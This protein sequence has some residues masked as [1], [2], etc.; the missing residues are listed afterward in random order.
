MKFERFEKTVDMED[1]DELVSFLKSHFRYYTANSWNRATSY[2]NN[3]KL[4][5]LN[6]PEKIRDKAYSLV[7]G[8]VECPDWNFAVE[9]AF[10]SFLKE[11]G[12]NAGF[13]GR[14]GGYIVMYETAV[15][16]SGKTV[17]YPGRGIDQYE[18]FDDEDEWDFHRLQERVK[19]VQRFDRVCDQLREELIY[20]LSSSEIEEYPVVTYRKRLVSREEAV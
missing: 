9:D 19:L 6:L 20:I 4:Y 16:S 18:D 10:H 11:T 2:A 7:C 17:T 3:V 12:Y 8:E 13:N 1:R 5:N 14:S 15:D